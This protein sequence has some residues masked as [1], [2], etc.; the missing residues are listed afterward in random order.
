MC[1]I[2]QTTYI[3]GSGGRVVDESRIPCAS[4]RAG[5]CTH[6]TVQDL[7]KI[8]IEDIRSRFA[9][10]AD[11]AG[12]ISPSG[13]S[14]SNKGNGR[15]SRATALRNRI[16][17]TRGKKSSQ[18]YPEEPYIYDPADD[19]Y[20]RLEKDRYRKREALEYEEAISQE[21]DLAAVEIPSRGN[22]KSYN[23]SQF[24]DTGSLREHTASSAE[25]DIS[26]SEGNASHKPDRRDVIWHSNPAAIVNSNQ[27]FTMTA[28]LAGETCREDNPQ[29]KLRLH[30]A[31]RDDDHAM[32]SSQELGVMEGKSQAEITTREP[33]AAAGNVEDE[34]IIKRLKAIGGNS[35]IFNKSPFTTITDKSA[36]IV[37]LVQPDEDFSS[38]IKED[39]PTVVQPVVD[40]LRRDST[41]SVSTTHSPLFEFAEGSNVKLSPLFTTQ[42][43]EVTTEQL[44][45]N[46]HSPRKGHVLK[47]FDVEEISDVKAGNMEGVEV[48]SPDSVEDALSSESE[49][50]SSCSE[51][52]G[53]CENRLFR[54][55]VSLE[56][57]TMKHRRLEKRE[58]TVRSLKRDL[59]AT[60]ESDTDM[61]D[62]S[63]FRARE[64]AKSGRRQR[65]RT[66]SEYSD[67]SIMPHEEYDSNDLYSLK[68]IMPFADTDSDTRKMAF[69]DDSILRLSEDSLQV[70]DAMALADVSQA[71][72]PTAGLNFNE[73][74]FTEKAKHLVRKPGNHETIVS[75]DEDEF[76]GDNDSVFSIAHSITTGM[77]SATSRENTLSFH[78]RLA[79]LIFEDKQLRTLC[80]IGLEDDTSTKDRFTRNLKRLIQ[81]MA[82]DLNKEDDGA[83]TRRASRFIRRQA[84][85]VSE[86][87]CDRVLLRLNAEEPR[88]CERANEKGN[89]LGREAE[90]DPRRSQE[91]SSDREEEENE[92]ERDTEDQIYPE[93]DRLNALILNSKAFETFRDNLRS[94]VDTPYVTR[95]RRAL[96]PENVQDNSGGDDWSRSDAEDTIAE[97]RHVDPGSITLLLGDEKR[98]IED[99][100]KTQVE[101]LTA[102]KWD[103]WPL[104]P[105]QR[106]LKHGQACGKRHWKEVPKDFAL[107]LM[108]SLKQM[109][110]ND[111]RIASLADSSSRPAAGDI[112]GSGSNYS[113]TT[114]SF[115]A[116]QQTQQTLAVPTQCANPTLRGGNN[117]AKSS[118]GA[119]SWKP[120]PD[121]NNLWQTLRVFILVQI[122]R[123]YEVAQI[124]VNSGMR[125]KAFFSR[126]R[127]DYFRVRGFFRSWFSVWKFSHCEFYKCNKFDEYSVGPLERGFPKPQ[128]LDY[129]FLPKPIDHVPPISPTQFYHNFY[130]CLHKKS[131]FCRMHRC[132]TISEASSEAVLR[133]PKRQS[134]LLLGSDDSETF[135]GIYAR[136][137]P[138]A[139]MVMGYNIL[140][141]TLPTC[142]FFVWQFALGHPG[143]LQNASIPLG[144]TIALLAIFWSTFIESLYVSRDSRVKA[145]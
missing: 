97:L 17:R 38:R 67:N 85:P 100:V 14:N 104:E 102:T 105:C 94:F 42:S 122:G 111:L 109:R 117:P 3:D 89:G 128:N 26:G 90:V 63:G 112:V 123:D 15:R 21:E 96:M 83:D 1:L 40:A 138:A 115:S 141:L 91:N 114:Q 57:G 108:D 48:V 132:K 86:D 55:L 62:V 118:S 9:A 10:V 127:N 136:E 32:T 53:N 140:A 77:T 8:L 95:L 35:V 43:D 137:I 56:N 70:P 20:A 7:G 28:S 71:K 29:L 82:L 110:L 6:A 31:D 98:K 145:F 88:A 11:K 65:P 134:A 76:F 80:V 49:S 60:L 47:D 64:L 18:T 74:V 23:N 139:Y 45:Q 46:H 144:L 24:E 41:N 68:D 51:I 59:N 25:N 121:N 36:P 66:A 52:E 143:D 33:R 37:P 99:L 27:K 75:D 130:A 93:P 61:E 50:A 135:F 30:E 125:S 113:P 81:T 103:W 58:R 5:A 92:A 72:S 120:R 34:R 126:M 142:F 54:A 4:Y 87:I 116:Q 79:D 124:T 2:Q 13:H 129:E 19:R 69:K 106:L 44:G 107:H 12:Q 133:L 84:Q 78:K 101:D 22:R 119:T 73:T 131:R 39:R 16:S